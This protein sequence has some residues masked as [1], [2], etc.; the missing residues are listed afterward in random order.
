MAT[1]MDDE[2]AAL[3]SE[4]ART[5][6]AYGGEADRKEIREKVARSLSAPSEVAAERLS[7][8]GKLGGRLNAGRRDLVDAVKDGLVSVTEVPA[9]ELPEE[10]RDLE[11]GAREAYVEEKA[12]ERQRIQSQID[13]VTA[14]RDAYVK[15]EQERLAAEGKGDG[16][17]Q[18]V[19]ETI[20][21]QA[22]AA[23]IAYE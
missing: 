8:L 18:Q 2:L 3:G 7:F 4:L 13:E 15:F 20:R 6:I 22:A 23:G 9:S 17:D 14:K 10:L 12:A 1:P 5:T 19:V 16:F 11:P 21:S